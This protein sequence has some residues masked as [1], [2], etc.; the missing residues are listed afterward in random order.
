MFKRGS[1]SHAGGPDTLSP[2]DF[3]MPE[4]PEVETTLRGIA[5]HITGQRIVQVTVRTHRL[6]FDIPA[7]LATNISG[8]RV[9]RVSRRAK[10]LLFDCGKGTIILHLGMS[11]SLRLLLGP[12]V[13]TRH[14]HVDIQFGNGK[15]VR[16]RDPRRFGSLLWTQTDALRHP[17][18]VSLGVEP[19]SRAFD[20]PALVRLARGRQTPIKQLLMDSHAIAG[21]GN[22]YAAESLFRAGIDPR[23]P[24][25]R[26]SA[27]RLARLVDDIKETLNDAITAGGSS[28]RDFVGAGGEAGHFQQSYFVYGRAGLPCRR[29]TT[30]LKNSRLGQRAS[31]FCPRCQT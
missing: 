24:A 3:I 20:K 17:L 29:C 6:R 1:P 22:I 15:I 14:D 7:E 21:V 23:R 2:R 10:Y 26:I 5:P 25:G 8:T 9:E 4:L 31:V 16:F 13:P 19:L 27:A 12:E 30:P 18:L 28:L 11:G